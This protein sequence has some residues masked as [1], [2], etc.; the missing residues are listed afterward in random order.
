[1]ERG[2][3]DHALGPPKLHRYSVYYRRC[4]PKWVSGM[5]G[6]DAWCTMH[7]HEALRPEA[8]IF[9]GFSLLFA[10]HSLTI[11]V[12]RRADFSRAFNGT[13]TGWSSQSESTLSLALTVLY[14]GV[15]IQWLIS[16]GSVFIDTALDKILPHATPVGQWAPTG[17]TRFDI[18]SCA[19]IFISSA[20]T[21]KAV[22]IG[23]FLDFTEF[24]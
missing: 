6:H 23:P 7:V 15:L 19:T 18:W 21:L 2:A 3:L 8:L 11:S 1:M 13:L 16:S 4:A 24:Y 10:F 9:S 17:Y 22:G 20:H 5:E 14:C 12:H